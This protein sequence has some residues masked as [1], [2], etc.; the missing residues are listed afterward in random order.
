[1]AEASPRASDNLSAKPAPRRRRLGVIV[2]AIVL[3]LAAVVVAV[4][5]WGGVTS[6]TPISPEL[7]Q[8]D[9]PLNTHLQDLM[10]EVSP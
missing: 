8:V 9:E 10:D 3:A 5:V 7:P 2:G 4:V 1:M 6:S